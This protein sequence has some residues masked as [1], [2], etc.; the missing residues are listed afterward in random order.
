MT[1]QLTTNPKT[2]VIIFYD[3]STQYITEREQELLF[4][5]EHDFVRVNGQVIA[6][7]NISKVLTIA[8][9]HQQ[10]PDTRPPSYEKN[11]D[12]KE[13]NNQDVQY[14]IAEI[15]KE[16]AKPDGQGFVDWN[17]TM[18]YKWENRLLRREG[19]I[20]DGGIKDITRYHYWQV[21]RREW[22]KKLEQIAWAKKQNEPPV[23]ARPNINYER[24][25]NL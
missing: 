21:A 15:K 16:K 1:N 19:I 9:Y 5:A 23:E 12:D 14:L 3:K 11:S 8:E 24:V 4:K 7:K 13:A 22:E 20:A 10:Y 25:K 2:H 18:L 17:N 6:L